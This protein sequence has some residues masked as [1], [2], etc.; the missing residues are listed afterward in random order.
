MREIPPVPPTVTEAR[1]A[2]SLEKQQN[3]SKSKLETMR[4]RGQPSTEGES[5]VGRL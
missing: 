3:L 4:N 5:V 1:R 2:E